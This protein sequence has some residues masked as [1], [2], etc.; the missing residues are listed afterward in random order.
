MDIKK[1]IKDF[2]KRWKIEEN[3]DFEK[4]FLKFKFRVF[5]VLKGIDNLVTEK[6]ISSFCN[7]LGIPE[8]WHREFYGD[9]EWSTNIIDS[10]EGENDPVKFYWLLEVI[11]C[12]PFKGANTKKILA[13]NLAEAIYFSNI[14]LAINIK[15]SGEIIL[16]PAGEKELDQ[17][18]VNEVLSFLNE[19][20]QKH[21]IEALEYYRNRSYIKSAESLRRSLEEFLR[22]KLKNK[23]GLK[24]N[25]EEMRIRLKVNNRDPLIR[26]IISQV[27]SYLDQYFNE[28][29]KHKDGDIDEPESEYLI[30]QTGTLMRFIEKTI[31]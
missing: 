22:F 30:Y 23:K 29:S 5:N 15:D 24:K 31:K 13:Q 9:L 7:I 27:F 8:K 10:L 20:S 2:N 1:K 4:E 18:L 17:K 16:Y 14:N 12:L 6:G 26:N 19:E 11:F 3:I 28:N 21:F 25:I